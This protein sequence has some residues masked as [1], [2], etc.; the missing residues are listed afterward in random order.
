MIYK[1]LMI[2][3]FLFEFFGY[4]GKLIIMLNGKK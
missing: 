3:L 1:I 4:Y 2:Y